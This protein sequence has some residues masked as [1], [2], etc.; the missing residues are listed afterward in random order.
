MDSS[1]CRNED[2]SS[3]FA[4]TENVPPL[5]FVIVVSLSV[6]FSSDFSHGTGIQNTCV[7]I[8]CC[9]HRSTAFFPLLVME[10]NCLLFSWM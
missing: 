1:I 2:S 6:I 8:R 9:F 3:L 5:T 4:N 10:Y 7:D